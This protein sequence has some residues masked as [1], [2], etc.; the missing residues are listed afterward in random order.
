MCYPHGEFVVG[1]NDVYLGE[2]ADAP[3]YISQSQFEYWQHTQLII[4][5]VEERGGMFSL[6]NGTGLRFLTCSHLH[7]DEEARD[8]TPI[9]THRE[10]MRN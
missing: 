7:N 4:D 8:L 3:F 9:I 2:I 5:V 6:D 1:G 10:R